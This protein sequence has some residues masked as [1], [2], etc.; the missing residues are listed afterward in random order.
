MARTYLGVVRQYLPFKDNVGLFSIAT[1]AH[2]TESM[3]SSEEM[4][5]PDSN[6]D[7]AT[8]AE[9]AK[10]HGIRLTKEQSELASEWRPAMVSSVEAVRRID[11]QGYEPAAVFKPVARTERE[12]GD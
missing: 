9:A 5:S 12:D 2:H 4:T 10:R 6:Q 3:R 11:V 8:L 7:A 1:A